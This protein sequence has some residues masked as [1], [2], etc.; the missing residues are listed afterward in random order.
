MIE[1]NSLQLISTTTA[2]H[3]IWGEQC[4]GWFLLKSDDVHVIQESMPPGTAEV[5]HYH[6]KSM[7]LFYVLHGEL[8]MRTGSSSVRIPAGHAVVVQPVMEHQARNESQEPVE[9]LVISCPPSRGDRF[10]CK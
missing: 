9:F 1:Q 7:Q 5:T 8:T 10:D 6:L 3:Y 2:E 4:D